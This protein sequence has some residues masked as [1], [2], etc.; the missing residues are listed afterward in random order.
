M[1]LSEVQEQHDIQVAKRASSKASHKAPQA[2]PSPGG[3]QIAIPKITLVNA[4]PA[5][6]TGEDRDGPSDFKLDP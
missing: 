3:N 1:R 6:R 5:R 2:W 4:N